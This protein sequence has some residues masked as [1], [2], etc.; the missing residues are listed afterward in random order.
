MTYE[1]A[2]GWIAE[3]VEFD[4]NETFEQFLSRVRESFYSQALIDT[5]LNGVTLDR[6]I[7]GKSVA[8]QQTLEQ[9]FEELRPNSS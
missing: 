5:L 7:G 1:E 2:F 3:N 6:T 4:E 9:F 8:Y